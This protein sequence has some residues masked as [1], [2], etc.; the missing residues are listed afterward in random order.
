MDEDLVKVINT[1]LMPN[2]TVVYP[3]FKP[4]FSKYGTINSCPIHY[5]LFEPEEELQTSHSRAIWDDYGWS[6]DRWVF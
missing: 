6:K 1:D 2:S 5:G 4:Y 3:E